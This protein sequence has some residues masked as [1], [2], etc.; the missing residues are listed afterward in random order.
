MI[1]SDRPA[2]EMRQ[3]MET[4]IEQLTAMKGAVVSLRLEI[5]AEVPDGDDRSKVQML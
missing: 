2:L 4:V 1:S 3:I 5:D